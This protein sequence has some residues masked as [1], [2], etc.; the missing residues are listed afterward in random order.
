MPYSRNISY[1]TLTL[2]LGKVSPYILPHFLSSDLMRHS[3]ENRLMQAGLYLAQREPSRVSVKHG[4][5][6]S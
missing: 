4:V 6:T 1:K 5:K 3:E 2:V